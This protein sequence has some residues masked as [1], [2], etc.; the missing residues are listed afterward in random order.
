MGSI[1]RA[2]VRF[3]IP[4]QPQSGKR[5]YF[6]RQICQFLCIFPLIFENTSGKFT[7]AHFLSSGMEH[8]HSLGVWSKPNLRQFLKKKSTGF[9]LRFYHKIEFQIQVF[10]RKQKLRPLGIDKPNPRPKGVDRVVLK[11][12]YLSSYGKLSEYSSIEKNIQA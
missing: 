5:G 7:C 11:R 3:S 1:V 10:P 8:T 4:S 6:A 12:Q 2:K 9:H